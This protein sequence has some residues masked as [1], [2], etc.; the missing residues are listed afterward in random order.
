MAAMPASKLQSL[1][2]LYHT[3]LYQFMPF[4]LIKS[5]WT[6]GHLPT[7]Q[8]KSSGG[9]DSK[10]LNTLHPHIIS[11][12]FLIQKDFNSSALTKYF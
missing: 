12:K 9:V 8:F 11:Y 7:L 3:N 1:N 4:K 5:T 10:A 6:T 2:Y